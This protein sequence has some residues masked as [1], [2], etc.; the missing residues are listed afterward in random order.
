MIVLVVGLNATIGFV[1]ETRAEATLKAAEANARHHRDGP[2]RVA[3]DR[4]EAVVT[5]AG[6]ANEVG[7]IAGMLDQAQ[8]TQTPLQRQLDGYPMWSV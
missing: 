3:R 1:Q 7:R 6:M 2:P 5:A 8:P 4:G